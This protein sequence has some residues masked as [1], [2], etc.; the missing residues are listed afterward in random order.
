MRRVL[1][2]AAL[3]AVAGCGGADAHTTTVTVTKP[4]AKPATFTVHGTMQVDSGTSF[5]GY[6]SSADGYDDVQEGTAVVVYNPAGTKVAIGQLGP[7]KPHGRSTCQYR[8]TVADVPDQ[9]SVYS[10]E[11]GH[12]GQVNYSRHDLDQPVSLTLQ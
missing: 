9:W 8:F 7:G 3:L 11:V 12:R 4:P 5:S 2:A 1:A 6:C 10:I